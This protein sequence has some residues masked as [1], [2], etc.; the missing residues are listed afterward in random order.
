MASY[1]PRA[2]ALGLGE[3]ALAPAA[4]SL[5]RDGVEEK[6]RG[7]AFSL[8]QSGI[9]L[10]YGLG[11]LIGGAIFELASQGFFASVPLFGHLKPW[12]QVLFMPGLCGL[13]VAAL[14]LTVREQR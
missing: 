6:Y 4:Y 11:A 5:M 3:S 9:T 2:P 13:L 7:R 8:Y 12:Q 1:S 10:G 14:L